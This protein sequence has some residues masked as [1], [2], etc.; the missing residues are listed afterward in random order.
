LAE[1]LKE[2][3]AAVGPENFSHDPLNTTLSVCEFENREV[4][5][6]RQFHGF[7]RIRLKQGD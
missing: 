5:W 3:T 1:S 6:R 7:N 4:D 2:W